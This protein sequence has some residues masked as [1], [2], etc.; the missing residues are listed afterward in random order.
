MLFHQKAKGAVKKAVEGVVI[1]R[2]K[3]GQPLAGVE[4]GKMACIS[5]DTLAVSDGIRESIRQG[6]KT[7]LKKCWKKLEW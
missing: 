4:N 7:P 2:R 3:S 1:Q 6:L 5:P